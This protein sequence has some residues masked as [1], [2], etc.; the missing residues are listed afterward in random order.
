MGESQGNLEHT[1]RPDTDLT[2]SEGETK[3][4]STLGCPAGQESFNRIVGAQSGHP[5]RYHVSP[6]CQKQACLCVP[7]VRLQT[8][9]RW[10]ACPL[11]KCLDR[12]QS[13]ATGP[14]VNYPTAGGLW[15]TFLQ[16]PEEGIGPIIYS[17]SDLCLHLNFTSI[18]VF[19]NRTDT[20]NKNI[21]KNSNRIWT[22]GTCIWWWF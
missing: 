6:V 5:S 14:S 3:E 13:R 11:W 22:L 2:P 12:L 16:L 1:A 4:G 18:F 19:L 15:G 17:K 8:R 20:V 21:H 9:S 10:E 7:A